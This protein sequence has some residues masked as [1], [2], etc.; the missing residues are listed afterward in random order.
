MK[1]IAFDSEKHFLGRLCKHRHNYQNTSQSARYIYNR[2]CVVCILERQERYRG[3]PNR[4]EVQRRYCNSPK[5]Q[6][7]RRLY[8]QSLQ[9]QALSRRYENSRQGKETRRRY[10]QSPKGKEVQRRCESSAKTQE[11]RRRYHHSERGREVKRLGVARYNARKRSNLV[12]PYTSDDIRKIKEFFDNCCAYCGVSLEKGC[13]IDHVVP[14]S[15]GGADAIFNLVPACPR[16]NNSKND[17]LL[18]EW[19]CQQEF[20]SLERLIRILK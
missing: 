15:K 11:V 2:E 16:C 12:I 17:R 19:Y 9:G 5:G 1:I 13:Q 14:I 18:E 3:T 10:L 7:K 8:K 20:F 6:E 4:K